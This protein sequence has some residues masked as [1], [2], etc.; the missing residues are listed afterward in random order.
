MTA[1][2][3]ETGAAYAGSQ[4]QTQLYV[5]RRADR[6]DDAIKDEFADL[7]GATIEWRGPLAGDAYRE[8]W[9]A[10]FLACVDL[11]HH[12]PELA[13]FWP[14][15]EPHWDALA[16]VHQPDSG[17]PGVLLV[18]GKSYV[19]E[20][21]GSGTAAKPGS[22]SRHL[23]ETSLAW[24]QRQLG[25]ATSALRTG[26]GG[27]TSPLT[28]SRTC[29]GYARSGSGRGWYT[30]SSPMTRTDRRRRWSGARRSSKPMLSSASTASSC[31]APA[32][33]SCPRGREELLA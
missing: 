4:L 25:S 20:L 15:R 29:P 21:F 26:A 7:R 27:C 10:P 33:C 22:D 8:Y 30:S 24:T 12:Q 11:A 31:R 2:Q 6:L 18:E 14:A 32:T 13:S 1:R 17:R 3:D 19:T 5:N 28:G 9:D 23:I 16:V